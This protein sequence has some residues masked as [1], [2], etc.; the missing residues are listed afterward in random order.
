MARARGVL[1]VRFS[2]AAFAT[3]LGVL[4]KVVAKVHKWWSMGSSITLLPLDV[5]RWK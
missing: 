2:R 5:A 3:D 4:L 1:G